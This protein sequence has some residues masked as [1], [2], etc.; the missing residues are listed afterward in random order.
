M[1]AV[2]K[3]EIYSE[4]DEQSNDAIRSAGLPLLHSH[5]RVPGHPQRA[6]DGNAGFGIVV[7]VEWILT[8]KR[9]HFLAARRR[10]HGSL[11]LAAGTWQGTQ[12][13]D[14]SRY[15]PVDARSGL[16][17]QADE[18]VRS[19][20]IRHSRYGEG[21]PIE[22][23]ADAAVAAGRC[24]RAFYL[25]VLRSISCRRRNGDRI[26]KSR[27]SATAR[28]HVPGRSSAV[29]A[30]GSQSGALSRSKTLAVGIDGER[31]RGQRAG[32]TEGER[33]KQDRAM[34]RLLH[35]FMIGTRV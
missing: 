19:Y 23:P 18:L 20:T 29:G 15:A 2:R 31:S 10:I 4:I 25:A 8:A 1:M 28:D 27:N 22:S 34:N 11:Q 17:R 13:G 14:R 9:P 21:R 35:G 26:S 32:D 5:H 16:R 6:S 33:E 12:V 24:D 7:G 30:T 3:R